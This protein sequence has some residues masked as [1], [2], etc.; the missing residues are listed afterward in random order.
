ML[1]RQIKYFQSIVENN[2]FSKA[3][4]EC[5]ISQSAISQQMQSLEK[6][7][8][9]RLF[10]R[11]NRKFSLTEAGEHFYKRTL[12]ISADL[13]QLKREIVRIDKKDEPL[14]SLG[15]LVSYDGKEFHG[16][17]SAFSEKHPEVKLNV[18]SGNHEDLYDALRTEKIDLALNDQRR[19]FSDDYENVV[20]ARTVLSVEIASHN[21]LSK[22]D[23]VDIADLKNTPCILVAAKEQEE[24]ER[25]YYRD[26][27][28]FSGEF[29]FA[30]TLRDARVMVVSNRG[31]L[32]SEITK[33]DTPS[34]WSVKRVPLTR[35]GERI[36]RNYCAFYKKGNSNR[37]VEEFA[38]MLAEAFD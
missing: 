28:G 18:I 37:H 31:V 13:E 32:P 6:E 12:V 23:S 15:Y 4:D 14:L 16:A 29:L 36:A 21:P 17:I 10:E 19:A 7:L 2:S 3:A 1:L 27:V 5:F 34:S 33:N 30:P 38:K 35:R 8:G 26:I 22:L 9:V 24:E 25:R 20:L 11:R